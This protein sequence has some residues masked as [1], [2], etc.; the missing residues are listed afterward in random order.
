MAVFTIDSFYTPY[1]SEQPRNYQCLYFN[2]AA[3]SEVDGLGVACAASRLSCAPQHKTVDIL[4][5]LP[6]RFPLSVAHE[7]AIMLIL[8]IC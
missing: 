7:E 1:L 5:R 2:L 3:P 8:I 4:G 6:Y